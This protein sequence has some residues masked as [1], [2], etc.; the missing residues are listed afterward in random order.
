MINKMPGD[1][2]AIPQL[3]LLNLREE[4]QKLIIETMKKNYVTKEGEA[5]CSLVEELT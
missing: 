4:S 2:L 1:M 5:G 3:E